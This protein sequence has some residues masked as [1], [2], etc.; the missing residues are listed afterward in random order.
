MLWRGLGKKDEELE[1]R[2]ESAGGKPRECVGQKV[3]SK[4]KTESR[5]QTV[6]KGEESTGEKLTECMLEH[7]LQRWFKFH[8]YS[9]LASVMAN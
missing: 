4:M 7:N 8:P 9:R 2:E 6:E 3:L 1:L 5:S